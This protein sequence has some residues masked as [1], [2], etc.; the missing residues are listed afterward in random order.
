MT[1]TTTKITTRTIFNKN[2][3]ELSTLN[4]SSSKP[5]EI[6]ELIIYCLISV[7]VS[8][9]KQHSSNICNDQISSGNF[10]NY[11]NL[12]TFNNSWIIATI[13]MVENFCVS[14]CLSFLL[15]DLPMSFIITMLIP[16]KVTNK[17]FKEN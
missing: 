3:P 17:L 4:Q 5:T 12:Y 11:D 14:S 2:S 16:G 10:I 15:V 9:T 13:E 6:I 7:S 8:L 1:V